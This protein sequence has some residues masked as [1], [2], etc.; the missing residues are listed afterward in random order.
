MHSDILLMNLKSLMSCYVRYM[1]MINIK[2][3]VGSQICYL[4]SLLEVGDFK[5]V[6]KYAEIAK[7]RIAI[8]EKW[9]RL[10]APSNHG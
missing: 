3:S 9:R 8:P 2:S 7:S 6:Y 10:D 5:K 4:S 1:V